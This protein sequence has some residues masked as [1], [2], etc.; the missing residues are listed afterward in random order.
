MPPR[1]ARAGLPIAAPKTARNKNRKRNLD[2]YSI[3]SHAVPTSRVRQNR[4]GELLDDGPQQKRRKVVDE[5]EDNDSDEDE[6]LA[7][8]QKP[9]RNDADVEEGSDSDGNQW[10]LGGLREDDE[11]SDLDS[12]GAFDEADEERFAGFAFRGSSSGK[13]KRPVKSKARAVQQYE[14]DDEDIDLSEENMLDDAAEDDFG[15]EGVDLATMLDDEDGHDGIEDADND[16]DSGEHEESSQ[17]ES[18]SDMD[19]DENDDALDEERM[20]RMR[21]RVEALDAAKQPAWERQAVPKSTGLTLEALLAASGNSAAVKEAVRANKKAKPLEPPLPQRQQDRISRKV[22]SQKAN[23][24]LDRWL[25]TVKQRREAE[26]LSFPLPDP[27]RSEP[28][29]KDKFVNGGVPQNEFEK[30]MHDILEE[31]GM[32]GPGNAE[33]DAVMKS[34]QLA[35]NKMSVQEVMERRAELRRRRDLLF[36]AE[37]KAKRISKIKSKAYRRVHRRERERV[38]A[39]ER[40]LMGSGDEEEREIAERKRAEARM[41]TKHKDS[42]WAKSLKAT[43]RTLWDDEAR[44]G[45]NELAR[46]N[47]ELRRRIAGEDVDE[48]ESTDSNDR[49]SDDESGGEGGESRMLKKLD[50][51]KDDATSGEQVKGLAGLDFMRAA[52]ERQRKRNEGDIE[53]L[54]K[55][56]AVE[57]GDENEEENE[58]AIDDQGLGRAIFGPEAKEQREPVKKAK[59]PELEEGDASETDEVE[60]GDNEVLASNEQSHMAELGKAPKQTNAKNNK[61]IAS[62]G[63]LVEREPK[64]SATDNWFAKLAKKDKR[65]A[66]RPDV[67]SA[68]DEAQV[69]EKETQSD[70]SHATREAAKRKVDASNTDGWT[71]VKYDNDDPDDV[72]IASGNEQSNPILTKQEQRSEWHRRAFAGDNVQTAFKAEKAEAVQSE[73]EKEVSNHLPGWGSWTGEGLSKSVKKA[74]ARQRHNPLF[75]TKLPGVRTEDRKDAKLENVIISEKSDRKGKKYQADILPHSYETKQQYE[76]SLRVPMGPEWVTKE[77]FQRRTKPRVL[78]KPGVVISAMD[79]PL[80]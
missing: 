19:E 58:E 52:D 33:E 60:A 45:V 20:A 43:N 80:V 70:T 36:D 75:K 28:L 49:T 62:S 26:H 47:E 76:R 22:A 34:E 50:R 17:S 30:A 7:R 18:E 79:K 2:A 29:G 77:T 72:D 46:R 9:N 51:L 48:A 5:D 8:K 10:I 57:D 38:A 63:L 31:S 23:E 41:S 3:A 66:G 12:D 35:E 71:L 68:V 42:K 65:K 44:Y 6:P 32:V 73:D 27:E 37:R 39:H 53:R 64:A 11:D 78:V 24:Q 16:N 54:R 67:L 13:S 15:D 21:D 4:L 69:N 74:N 1:K 55:E 14:E 61:P 59:R 40:E 25:P 56:L